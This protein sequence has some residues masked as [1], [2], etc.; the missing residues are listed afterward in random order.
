MSN[1]QII[2][3]KN[4]NLEIHGY[5]I[6]S[7]QFPN[8][9]LKKSNIIIEYLKNP[10]I[11]KNKEKLSSFVDELLNIINNNNTFIIPFIDPCFNI[12]KEYFNLDID[13]QEGIS[14]KDT[15]KFYRLFS[16]LKKITFINKKNIFPIYS[17]FTE[18]YS[19]IN[20]PKKND[21]FLKKILMKF[22]KYYEFW[23]LFY[24]LEIS[25]M[26]QSTFCC[27]GTGFHLEISNFKNIP[28]KYSFILKIFLPNLK[29]LDYI[30][31]EDDII[32]IEKDISIKY[33]EITR[34][35]EN[36]YNVI[37]LKINFNTI[38][39]SLYNDNTQINSKIT[40]FGSNKKEL[41]LDILSNFYGE[42]KNVDLYIA[43]NYQNKITKHIDPLPLKYN[44]KILLQTFYNFY[45]EDNL[46]IKIELSVNNGK[47]L[48][49]NFINYAGDKFDIIE[50]YG[51]VKTLLPFFNIINKIYEYDKITKINNMSKNEVLI[52]FVQN[53]LL[54]IFKWIN[55]KYKDK[56][57]D[58][59]KL[60]SKYCIFF[61]EILNKI[62][63]L[64]T[65]PNLFNEDI[66]M[67]KFK[68]IN[69]KYKNMFSLFLQIIKLDDNDKKKKE[70]EFEKLIKEKNFETIKTKN[71]FSSIKKMPNQLYHNI[72]KNLF[73]FNRMWS[74][75]YLFFE[76]NEL[77]FT[78]DIFNKK[79]KIKY[80]QLNYHTKNYQQA[81]I[82]PI[83]DIENYYPNFSKLQKEKL[84]KNSNDDILNYNFKLPEKNYVLSDQRLIEKYFDITHSDIIKCCLVKK[85]YHIKGKMGFIRNETKT[86][87]FIYFYSFIY[88][89]FK[90]N[91]NDKNT[92]S[93]SLNKDICYGST[94]SC[95]NKEKK[96]ILYFKS[97]NIMFILIREYFYRVSAIEI[98]MNNNKSYFFNFCDS[99]DINNQTSNKILNN[100]LNTNFKKIETNDG[101]TIGY[102]NP[103]YKDTL[104]P[105]FEENENINI[106][107][108]KIYYYSNYDKLILINLLSNR[109]FRDLYQYPVFP[110]LY[111]ILGKKRDMKEHIGFQK[112]T[113]KSIARA[114]IF[115][116]EYKFKKDEEEN[117]ETE[118][119]IFLFSFFYSNI[120]YICN[121]LIRVIPYSFIGIELQGD[122]FDDPNRLFF[123]V[124]N[125]LCNTINQR[126]DL[127]E[128]I[129]EFF[130]FP[131]LFSN[132][133]DFQ[134]HK[135]RDDTEDIDEVTIYDSEKHEECDSSIKKIINDKYEFL[136]KK[137]KSLEQRND[138][139]LWIDLI[140]GK[141]KERNENNELYFDM[142]KN[143]NYENKENIFNDETAMQCYDFGV[144]PYQLF[145]T[146]FPISKNINKKEIIFFNIEQFKK[147]HSISLGEQFFSFLC[148]GEIELN[149]NYLE[150]ID[151]QKEF[152]F[153]IKSFGK[154]FSGFFTD[155]FN[156]EKNNIIKCLFIG[157][158][159]GD[160]I[161]Y[162]YFYQK[163][164]NITQLSKIKE[165]NDTSNIFDELNKKYKKKLVK[166]FSDHYNE[167]IYIDF[168]PRLNL[169]VDYALDG[170]INLYTFPSLKLVNVIHVKDYLD[171]IL[172]GVVLISRPY[173]MIFCY[174]KNNEMLFDINGNLINK[175]RGP[176]D[177][178]YEFAIDKNCGIVS[179][180]IFV[181]NKKFIMELP[182]FE[183]EIFVEEKYN[184]L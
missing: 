27:L 183:K 47:L 127:R 134:F 148:K 98:F 60:V 184:Y 42:I 112:I 51:G 153:S 40:Q 168:N 159:F 109:S 65:K 6:N 10:S 59:E 164:E 1:K 162:E 61:F 132:K 97:K 56:D 129:P 66:L 122:G 106:W 123:S 3:N 63:I 14:I 83:L 52:D 130:Y 82:Y 160:L 158:I 75:K 34:I 93:K 163:D 111:D 71:Y 99:F 84:Y 64:K 78:E 4:L 125:T 94:F 23:K 116:S 85:L 154:F 172:E 81:L 12:I 41:K 147:D 157:T 119:D 140:F 62:E 68:N 49:G 15:S 45:N 29:F 69:V 54:I 182:S 36:N 133:N 90:C 161:I 118:N 91:K 179:D 87:F 7:A 38:E 169:L 21:E 150:L 176:E 173:P 135:I 26:K 92:D 101:I 177:N 33:N 126:S 170:F 76:T 104:Y 131:P 115:E 13:E 103:I 114:K 39:V 120:I 28:E 156:E 96:R 19:A 95:S 46:Q 79:I 180:Y 141:N 143:I 181:N 32:K 24:D 88:E 167:I 107:D 73:I 137:M 20:S 43:E 113:P 145:K 11:I 77:D 124:E 30:N 9:N 67:N 149:K 108:N 22:N 72:M 80:K 2:T 53:I 175:V 74:K 117:E 37:I 55:D 8:D 178:I 50:Y 70:I 57:K 89:K 136:A 139:N 171:E 16:S 174:N 105:L 151:K 44:E 31:L 155:D 100:I 86:K 152:N 35:K 142:I 17:Y 110:M 48:K 138:I 166:I 128:S 121:Y 144:L 18:L 5:L 165:T 146:E 58:T 102:Y 25:N